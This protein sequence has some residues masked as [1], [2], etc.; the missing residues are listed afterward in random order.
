RG[1]ALAGVEVRVLY[2]AIGSQATSG[3][4]FRDLTQ[5]GVQVQVFHSLWE[6]LWRFSFLRVLN[7]RDHRKLLVLDDQVAYFGGMNL[8]DAASA[9]TI[10]Q[11][12]HLPPSAGWRDV[13]VRLKGP[14]QGEVAESFER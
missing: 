7:R 13:H 1:R 14:Q 8:V 6:A 2:D 12:E 5:A 4:F 10:D 9:R 11:A 3:A